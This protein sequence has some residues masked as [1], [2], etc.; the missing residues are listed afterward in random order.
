MSKKKILKKLSVGSVV[1]F[2]IANRKGYAMIAKN[3]LTEG[4]SIPQAYGRMIKAC[5]RM[6]YELPDDKMPSR[7]AK[8]Q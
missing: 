8:F 4:R 3:N 2:K 5:R 6:G 7:L 1:V